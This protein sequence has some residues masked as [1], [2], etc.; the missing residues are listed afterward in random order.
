M[1]KYCLWLPIAKNK[2]HGYTIIELLVV[3]AILAILTSLA[4]PGLLFLKQNSISL[5]IDKLQIICQS[6][7]KKAVSIGQK[8]YLSFNVAN[9]SY[10]YDNHFERLSQGVFFGIIPGVKGPPAN[11]KELITSPVTFPGQ[12]I[13]FYPNGTIS[14]GTTY[15]TNQQNNLL[16]AITIPVSQVSFIR[17]YKYM[18]GT[19]LYLK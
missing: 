4:I 2:K 1:K 7:Q 8:Q 9:H 19:W 13:I 10:F 11:P 3:V 14:A 12:K 5:E 17:K 15:L 6:L 16:F 18:Y